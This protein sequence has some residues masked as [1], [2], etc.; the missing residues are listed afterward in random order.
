MQTRRL[1]IFSILLTG[2][3]LLSLLLSACSSDPS[4]VQSTQTPA[5]TVV[6][7]QP[8]QVLAEVEFRTT[9][10]AKL[11]GKQKLTLE[12]LDEVTGLALNAIRYD[13]KQSNE[14]QYSVKVA[15]QPGSVIKYRYVR[16]GG[17]TAIE[18]TSLG[19]QVR[20][21]MYYV[22]NPG[23]VDDII[24]AWNDTPYKSEYGRIQG[25]ILDANNKSPIVGSLVSA[26]GQ[27]SITA[28]DGTFLLDG[29]PPG[30]HNIVVY[31]LE[32]AFP[33]FQ[34]EAVVASN[35]ST[36]AGILLQPAKM[37]SVT[38]NVK[39]PDDVPEGIPIRLVG[40]T[41]GLGNTFS[42][43]RGGVSAIASRAPQLTYRQERVYSITLRLPVGLDLRYKYSL[44]D[45]FW[46]AERQSSGKFY[47]RQLV[48]PDSDLIIN[49]QIEAFTTP[50]VGAV[51]FNVTVSAAMAKD[52]SLSIQFNPYGWT[53]PI[54]MWKM[55]DNRWVYILY[56]P[57]DSDLVTD[58]AY[59][60]CK[61]DQCGRSDV[62]ATFGQDD[63]G[64]PF[65]TSAQPQIIK[66]TIKK[67]AWT[68]DSRTT[69]TVTSDP[70][71]PKPDTFIT[72]VELNPDY[73]P[74][75]L[76]YTSNA[77]ANI[78][79]MGAKWAILS[80]TWHFIS[81]NPPVF[82]QLPGAD[83]SWYDLSQMALQARQKGLQ[84]V[85]HPTMEYYQP[86][87]IWWSSGARDGNWW[88]SWFDRYETYILTHADLATQV[89]AEGLILGDESLAPAIPNGTL[90]DGS[91]SGV[92]GD[93]SLRWS[94]LI[95]K[96]R[97]HFK[98]EI[99]WRMNY[100]SETGN[101]PDFIQEVDK[102]YLVVNG[103]ITDAENPSK[104]DI[105]TAF[106]NKLENDLL[107]I[108]DHYPKPFILGISYPSAT[109]AAS[110]CIHNGDTCLPNA[111]F[112][113]SGLDVQAATINLN[114]QAEIYNAVFE[115]VNQNTWIK[116]LIADGYFPPVALQDKSI[117][118]R[119]KPAGDVVWF[120]FNHW[121]KTGN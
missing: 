61:N 16:Q 112:E 84:V 22:L 72:G 28:S 31:S 85:I 114:E 89:G 100:P 48:I 27:Q 90:Q 107:T 99:I 103:Q 20:Y 116:G 121:L 91:S 13:M 113:Q 74:S 94:N 32:G 17:P 98:G 76:A 111:V 104:Q 18:Y 21:R 78:Q 45:G 2:S 77:F 36:P 23:T 56:T 66:D 34:Q 81:S 19:R 46:N 79:E 5:S 106:T 57:L 4:G 30:K 14:L 38:F 64:N 43:L 93:A 73:H 120:W 68:P 47:T 8:D 67:W 37:V 25:Q 75:W 10:P 70:I 35:A 58:A 62:E 71:T 51:T 39:A 110:G 12:V 44:G 119:G 118:I 102:I 92:P 80:P 88:Q 7:S 49:Q 26:G 69:I 42:D 109:G 83:A 63:P 96:I 87:S 60:Y 24:S 54:P 40:N 50:G 9:L 53:E 3:I 52:E 11:T 117:S 86:A 105:R 108:R 33:P 101:I 1:K 82:A 95:K 41:Y 6:V 59:R 115:A 55:G 65:K 97:T 15:F 29:L